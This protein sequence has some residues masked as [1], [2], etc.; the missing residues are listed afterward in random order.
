VRIPND[1]ELI[2][3]QNWTLRVR[4][5]T[6][7]P[8]RLLL[9]LHGWTGNEDSM[10]VFVRNFSSAHWIAA[11]RAIYA[12]EPSGYS[13]RTRRTHLSE[14]G[15]GPSLDDLRPAVSLLIDLV[16]DYSAQNRIDAS[17]FDVMGFS[18]GA[19]L[20]NALTLLHPER[21][22]RAGILSGFVPIGSESLIEKSSLNGKPFFV[23][24]GTLDEQVKVEYARQS[25]EMLE[26]AGARVTY[27]EDE[28]GHKLSAQGLRALEKFFA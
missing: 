28:I 10:W 1:T 12:A 22:R 3:F 2:T 9:L 14:T 26:R 23:A 20:T 11:P 27:C 21:V 15:G 7:L 25:V 16:D 6:T 19:A 18:Q 5:A 13:W 24:H 4:A 17:Q 8:A